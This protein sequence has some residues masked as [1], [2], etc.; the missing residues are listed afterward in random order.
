MKFIDLFAGL[1]GFHIA[2]K[3]IGHECVFASEIDNTLRDLYFRNF[4]IL[5]QGD[6]RSINADQIPAHDIL[7]AGFPCQPFSKAGKQDG[8]MNSEFGDLYSQILKVIRQHKPSYLILENV[9]NMENHDDGRTWGHIKKLIERE[10]YEIEIGHLS[11]HDFGIPQIRERVYIVGSRYGLNW[12]EFPKPSNKKNPITI[13][14]YLETKPKDARKVSDQVQRCIGT[15]QDFLDH[16]PKD[17][18]IIHPI[19]SME[20]GATY[21]YEKTIPHN[22]S[23]KALKRYR[24]SYGQ[25]LSDAV[26]R[27]SLFH[28]IPS[29]ARRRGKNFPKWKVEYIKKNRDFY[30]NHKSWLDDWIPKIREFPSSLQKLEWN[31]QGEERNIREYII[32]MRPSGVRVKRRTTAPSLVAMTATQVPIIPWEDRYMTP[33]ECMKLQSMDGPNGIKQLPASDN[34]AYE[35]LG[36]AIN[37]KVAK[38]VAKALVGIASPNSYNSRLHNRPSV[39]GNC[40]VKKSYQRK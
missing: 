9:P 37:V 15:W 10:G 11:P 24:G 31:C 1:G 12:F 14:T 40:K 19:W 34:K 4:G 28:M 30:E 22:M 27:N 36:N 7:C 39:S 5:P 32:Q 8:L 35:A 20:F 23:V 18:S 29:H 17:E 33:K 16:I 13:E 3:Q 6:I 2:L 21:P 26:D 25:L 38:I